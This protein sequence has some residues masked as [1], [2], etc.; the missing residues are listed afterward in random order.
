MIIIYVLQNKESKKHF[1]RIHLPAKPV[2]GKM[3]IKKGKFSSYPFSYL[4]YKVFISS[5]HRWL[6]KVNSFHERED[7]YELEHLENLLEFLENL[8]NLETFRKFTS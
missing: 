8:E 6:E 1:F 5:N 4:I 7:E 3:S 2:Y